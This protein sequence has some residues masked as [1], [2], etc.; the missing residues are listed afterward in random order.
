MAR[1]KSE[2]APEAL[3]DAAFAVA[4]DPASYKAVHKRSRAKQ[5]LRLW[6]VRRA[7][8]SAEARSRSCVTCTFR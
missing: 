3:R 2:L 7:A 8:D 5:Q 1:L 4:L 6:Q